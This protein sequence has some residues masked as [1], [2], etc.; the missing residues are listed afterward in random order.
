LHW[1]HWGLSRP[2]QLPK[3]ARGIGTATKPATREINVI[4]RSV[5]TVTGR[6]WI[7]VTGATAQTIETGRI[8]VIAAITK[9]PCTGIAGST[10]IAA[11][12]TTTISH[13]AELA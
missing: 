13:T 6:V 1:P 7:A 10:E 5:G 4:A 9:G 2:R 12:I 3:I 8:R 11:T